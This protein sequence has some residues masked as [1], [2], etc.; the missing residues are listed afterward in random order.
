MA[1][2]N[3]TNNKMTMA[4]GIKACFARASFEVV[5]DKAN[6]LNAGLGIEAEATCSNQVRITMKLSVMHLD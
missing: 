2:Q 5:A 1:A 3:L 6:R 4:A